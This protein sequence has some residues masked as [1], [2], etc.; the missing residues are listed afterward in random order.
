MDT[1]SNFSPL[2]KLAR[3]GDV[4]VVDR[5]ESNRETF[6]AVQR[7]RPVMADNSIRPGRFV[8]CHDLSD[9]GISFWSPESFLTDR[10]VVTFEHEDSPHDLRLEVCHQTAITCLHEPLYLIGCRFLPHHAA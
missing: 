10:L 9:Q 7:V 6:A 1:S 5:R 8:R 4:L 2:P 3:A